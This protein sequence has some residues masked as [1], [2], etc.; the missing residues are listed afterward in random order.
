MCRA[1]PF[2]AGALFALWIKNIFFDVDIVVEN[3]SKCGLSWSVLLPTTSTRHNFF[4]KHFF[5]LFLRVERRVW[6]SFCKRKFWRVQVA[7]LHNAAGALSSPSRCFPLSTNLDKDFCRCLWYFG[8]KTKQSECRLAWHWW[9]SNDLGLIDMFLCG[10]CRLYIIFQKFAPQA[11]SGKYF[12]IW[13]FPR[14]GRGGGGNEHTHA[15]FPGLSF[16]PAGR[17]ES[18]GTELGWVKFMEIEI[19]EHLMLI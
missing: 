4:P 13:F 11:E 3:K 18:P 5:V 7:Y 8:K 1:I 15:S 12:Q 10:N 14:F 9:N 2:S 19:F 6:E 17:K 16:H